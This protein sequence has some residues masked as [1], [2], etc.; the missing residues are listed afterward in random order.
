L[1]ERL[2]GFT[3]I[4]ERAGEWW[5]S[6]FVQSLKGDH[7]PGHDIIHVHAGSGTLAYYLGCAVRRYVKRD[8]KL[9]L[10]I[11]S[12]K[13]HAFPRSL[14]EVGW[15]LGCRAAHVILAVSE[16]SSRDI[17]R[18][19][20]IN[21]AKIEVVYNGVD[22]EVFL[23]LRTPGHGSRGVSTLVFCGR[24]NGTKQKGL[25]VL[26]DAMPLVLQERDVVLNVIA[27]GPR[28]GEYRTHAKRLKIDDRVRFLGFVEHSV[29]PQYYAEADLLV[30]PSRRES[31][32]LVL[33]EAMACGLPVVATTAGAIP[34]VVED[35]VTGVLVPPDDPKALANAVLSLLS[36]R[37]RLQAMGSAGVE[38]VRERFTWDKVAQRVIEGYHKVL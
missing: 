6:G 21:R 15:M 28:L 5:A 12:P 13:V 27:V 23:P 36:D 37:P 10:T 9:A 4:A 7:L 30:L 38:R 32:G 1:G 19:Y 34:E 17:T 22:T 33:A 2:P 29:L 25:E 35:G 16:F 31:F 18:C 20:R 14:D 26:L 3:H 8:V 24:L 11:H